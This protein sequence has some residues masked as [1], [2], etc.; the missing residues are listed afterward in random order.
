MHVPSLKRRKS[1][2]IFNCMHAPKWTS[3]KRI[4]AQ[5]SPYHGILLLI[6]D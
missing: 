6:R 2:S 4:V 1:L 3:A 5:L